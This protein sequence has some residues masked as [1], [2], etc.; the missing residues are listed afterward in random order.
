MGLVTV[1]IAPMATHF[2][3]NR[4]GMGAENELAYKKL[5]FT[6]QLSEAITKNEI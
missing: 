4:I 3:S 5:C 6:V 1:D 2:L